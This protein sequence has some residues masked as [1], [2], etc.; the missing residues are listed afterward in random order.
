MW[1]RRHPGQMKNISV[2]LEFLW[3]WLQPEELFAVQKT[4]ARPMASPPMPWECL[5]SKG[6]LGNNSTHTDLTEDV[7][8]TICSL[9]YGNN[10]MQAGCSASTSETVS[11]Y[12]VEVLSVNISCYNTR[13]F[14]FPGLRIPLRWTVARLDSSSFWISSLWKEKK[15]FSVLNKYFWRK[16]DSELS[17]TEERYFVLMEIC[18]INLLQKGDFALCC[19]FS[20]FCGVG[21]KVQNETT[22]KR[23]HL[24][25]AINA[26]STL[27]PVLALVSMN[28]TLYSWK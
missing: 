7:T 19:N 20:C 10:N 13:P 18:G 8:A 17:S 6:P 26:R 27:S 4:M 23:T 24:A 16:L 12:S 3:S 5:Q 15:T 14:A 1:D 22:T 21:R 25:I 9:F 11:S 28:A 2:N